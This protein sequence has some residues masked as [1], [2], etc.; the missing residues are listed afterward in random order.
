MI[1][2]GANKAEA[3]MARILADTERVSTHLPLAVQT[4]PRQ[5]VSALLK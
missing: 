1:M 5:S 2:A 3:A 4:A